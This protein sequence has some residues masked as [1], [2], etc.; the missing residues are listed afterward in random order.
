MNKVKELKIDST[1]WAPHTRL[2]NLLDFEPEK[3]SLET[4]NYI[5]IERNHYTCVPAIDIDSVLKI[6]NKRVYPQAYLEQC[7]DKLKKIKHAH[8]IDDEIRMMVV[9]VIL[10]MKFL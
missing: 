5:P 8:F 7:K 10:M 3:V 2:V 6:D 4:E 1:L 9:V